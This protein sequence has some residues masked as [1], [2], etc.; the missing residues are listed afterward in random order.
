MMNMPPVCSVA[1]QPMLPPLEIATIRNVP[2]GFGV[3]AAEVAVVPLESV[4]PVDWEVEVPDVAAVVVV[5][6]PPHAA[7][8]SVPTT[9][10]V[11]SRMT[12]SLIERDSMFRAPS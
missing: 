7:S 9:R 4:L 1:G 10:R 5:D 12:E 3:S 11:T 8:R 6:P 2:P